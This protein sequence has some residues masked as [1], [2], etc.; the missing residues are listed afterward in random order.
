[1]T[2]ATNTSGTFGPWGPKKFRA[3]IPLP[4]VPREGLLLFL[5][6]FGGAF[7]DA[8]QAIEF[9]KAFDR[10][11]TG[12]AL[13]VYDPFLPFYVA[14][15]DACLR[16]GNTTVTWPETGP[17]K[18]P[19]PCNPAPSKPSGNQQTPAKPSTDTQAPRIREQPHWRRRWVCRSPVWDSA[20]SASGDITP[21]FPP[22]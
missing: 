17:K 10:T 3:F 1:M 22:T 16:G 6:G 12:T 20:A 2:F 7:K 11:E 4:E 5:M 18:T 8:D 9:Y 21:N 19:R 14:A 13:K 15:G